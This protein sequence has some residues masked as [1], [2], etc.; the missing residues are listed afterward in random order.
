MFHVILVVSGVFV[1]DPFMG[2]VETPNKATLPTFFSAQ[3]F[4]TN[5]ATQRR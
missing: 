3:K 1:H 4:P 2:D 5:Q